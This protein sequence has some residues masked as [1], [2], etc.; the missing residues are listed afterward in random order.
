M[1]ASIESR[2]PFLDEAL[3]KFAVNLPTRWKLHRTLRF[4]DFRHPFIV[5]KYVIRKLAER[6]LPLLYWHRSESG[7]SRYTTIGTSGSLLDFS[8]EDTCKTFS[9]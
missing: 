2:F 5:D 8:R 6:M 3:L 7:G 9:A 1:M 4:H